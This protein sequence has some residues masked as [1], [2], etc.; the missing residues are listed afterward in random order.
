MS[1]IDARGLRACGATYGSNPDA[2]YY[3][4]GHKDAH[5]NRWGT[6]WANDGAR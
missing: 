6:T 2:C 3:P 1:E 4:E 5:S